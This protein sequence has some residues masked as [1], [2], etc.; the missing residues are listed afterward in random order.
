MLNGLSHSIPE[1]PISRALTCSQRKTVAHI[2]AARISFVQAV[3]IL[4]ET[5]TSRANLLAVGVTLAS[6]SDLFRFRLHGAAG[7]ILPHQTLNLIDLFLFG[8]V[9]CSEKLV[10]EPIGV[11]HG[12][13]NAPAV[14]VPAGCWIKD[15]RSSSKRRIIIHS[16]FFY[17][18]AV[19]NPQETSPGGI[20]RS[21]TPPPRDNYLRS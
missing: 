20:N 11:Q 19:I 2:I 14:A 21:N 3:L 8:R 4:S 10:L 13:I 16:S 7:E 5:S 6:I 9:C 15:H 12:S 17:C 18:T 1:F